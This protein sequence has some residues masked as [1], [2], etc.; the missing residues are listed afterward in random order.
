MRKMQ[1]KDSR[2]PGDVPGALVHHWRGAVFTRRTVRQLLGDLQ[3]HAPEQEDV[4][5]RPSSS[6]DRTACAFIRMQQAVTVT[7]NTEPS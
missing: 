5:L 3:S 6:A 4:L 2:A 1:I 7:Y